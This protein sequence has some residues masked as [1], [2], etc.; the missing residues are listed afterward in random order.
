MFHDVPE[1]EMRDVLAGT[2]GFGTS[3]VLVAKGG[4]VTYL[5]RTDSRYKGKKIQIWTDTGTGWT[6][7][8]S[9]TI[10]ADGSI[11]YHARVTGRTGFWAKFVDGTTAAT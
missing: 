7:P 10:A 5:V 9:R 3:T 4:Y 6:Q 1:A 2:D 11:H 8:T